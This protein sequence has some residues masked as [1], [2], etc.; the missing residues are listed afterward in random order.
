MRH[1]EP[2]VDATDAGKMLGSAD[3]VAVIILLF[4]HSCFCDREER[5]AEQLSDSKVLESWLESQKWIIFWTLELDDFWSTKW[6]QE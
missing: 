4:V 1:A 6:L 2:H 3:L 5:G